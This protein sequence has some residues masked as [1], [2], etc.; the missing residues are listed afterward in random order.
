MDEGKKSDLEVC[1]ALRKVKMFYFC[2]FF[3]FFIYRRKVFSFSHN[4]VVRDECCQISRKNQPVGW[5]SEVF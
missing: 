2:D 5:S 4:V 1:A 3:F